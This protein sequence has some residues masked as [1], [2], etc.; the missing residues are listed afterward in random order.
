MYQKESDSATLPAMKV[1]NHFFNFKVN[2]L[3]YR[4]MTDNFFP[5]AISIPELQKLV[6]KLLSKKNLGYHNTLWA[7]S[8]CSDEVNQSLHRLDEEFETFGPF[9]LGG[10]SGIPFA[11]NTGFKAFASHIPDDGGALIVYGPHI[12]ITEDG[13]IGKVHRAGQRANTSCCGSI[14]S[15]LRDISAADDT[16]SLPYDFQQKEVKNLLKRNWESIADAENRIIAATEVTY[17][18]IKH[19]IH[20]IVTSCAA[21]LEN[22]PLLTI[23]GILINT[24]PTVDDLFDVRDIDWY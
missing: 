20:E 14:I 15:A 12:G 7:T 18:E 11:G 23:G 22:K 16:E 17:E 9:T 24:D 1:T 3:Q 19:E 8:V 4:R 10:I 21:C 13:E 6:K 2:E 5:G